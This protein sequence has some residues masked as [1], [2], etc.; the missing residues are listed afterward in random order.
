MKENNESITAIL[1]KPLTWILFLLIIGLIF[2][3]PPLI[4]NFS[5]GEWA[6]YKGSGEIGD[7]I[8][9]ITAPIVNLI[10]AF[11]VFLALKAQI[12]A[13]KIIQQQITEDSS[14]K[15]LN[16]LFDYLN[17]TISNISFQGHS[18]KYFGAEAVKIIL[19][20]SIKL[21]HKQSIKEL[22]ESIDYQYLF[23]SLRLY[24]LFLKKLDSSKASYSEKEILN[25][26]LQ[27]SYYTTIYSPFYIVQE[28]I[29]EVPV[30]C[31]ICKQTHS[32]PEEIL[33]LTQAI[34]KK[35]KANNIYFAGQ[36][37]SEKL[38]SGEVVAELQNLV[39]QYK[40]KSE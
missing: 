9:G 18:H 35:I 1:K 5:I 6:N 2:S 38:R 8:G 39:K 26:L 20:N 7:A 28:N 15:D 30:N 19:T 16:K 33:N 11:L 29:K 3:I 4:I 40:Q 14:S 34:D 27:H 13:N 25:H 32:I 12:D 31:G 24:E 21:N 22:E 17:N 36:T 23:S 10:S 37:K